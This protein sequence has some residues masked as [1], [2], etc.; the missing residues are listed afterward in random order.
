MEETMSPKR[1]QS[2]MEPTDPDGDIDVDHDA[3]P[4]QPARASWDR[5]TFM[6]TGLFLGAGAIATLHGLAT[7]RPASAYPVA[8]QWWRYCYRCKGLFWKELPGEVGFCAAGGRHIWDYGTSF[9]YVLPFDTTFGNLGWPG[10]QPDWRFCGDCFQLTYAGFE[11]GWCPGHGRHLPLGPGYS[12]NYHL[13]LQEWG[14]VPDPR[15]HQAGWMYCGRCQNLSYV[16]GGPGPCAAGGSHRLGGHYYVPHFA[17]ASLQS[18]EGPAEAFLQAGGTG[19]FGPHAEA[20]TGSV[21]RRMR[22][23]N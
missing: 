8:Q 18:E 13:P 1:P 10:Y 2:A 7:A 21:G 22:G 9:N 3:G 20:G 11:V 17:V 5:R 12:H 15:I 6:K 4:S 23:A 19:L 14:F 16:G